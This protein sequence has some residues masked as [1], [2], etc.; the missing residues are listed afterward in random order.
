[1]QNT[2]YSAF[3]EKFSELLLGFLKSSWKSK[4]I[5]LLSVL[6]GYFLFNNLITN[7]LAKIDNKIFIVPFLIL[8]FEMIIRIKP[9]KK[10]NLYLLW[11]V[12]DRLRIGAIYALILEAFKLGS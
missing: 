4:S 7:F 5:N 12:F 8:F 11:Q 3:S 6:V 2:R 9:S 1:M 10:S